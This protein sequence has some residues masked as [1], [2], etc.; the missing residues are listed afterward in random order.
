[1]KT[2]PSP[3]R[4]TFQQLL[5]NAFAVQESHISTQSLSAVMDVQRLIASGKL[6]LDG[7]MRHIVESA[8]KVANATGVAIAVLKR[9]QLAY[10]AGIGSS[11]AHVGRQ[12]TASLTVSACAK[13]NREIL[14][15]EN[16]QTDTRIEA[17]ICRQFGANALLI[18]P[19]YND[20][21]VAGVL[22]VRF[23]EA[24]IFDDREVRTYRL[25][26]E[27][28]ESALNHAAEVEPQLDRNENLAPEL[29][30]I[31][32]APQQIAPFEAEQI[33]PP[34]ED[35]VPPPEFMMLPQNEHSLFARCGAVLAD[36]MQLAVFKQ[37]AWLVT[38]LT[39]PAKNLIRPRR[40]RP[41]SVVVARK[42][43]TFKRPTLLRRTTLLTTTR[44]QRPK[45]LARPNHW[46][47]TTQAAA[48]E[49]SSAF[50]RTWFSATTLAHRAKNVT[51]PNRWR[52]SARAAA[53][54]FSSVFR[55]T[56]SSA[57]LLAQRAKNLN[58][59]NRWRNSALAAG[60]VVLAFITLIA[61]RSADPAKSLESSTPTSE[62]AID[63][64]AQIPKPLAGKATAAVKHAAVLP[65]AAAPAK[66]ALR[67]V[68]VGSG[69]VEYIGDDVTVRTFTN[70]S[71]AKRTRV[72]AGRTANIGDDVTVRYFTPSPSPTKTATR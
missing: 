29:P 47:S 45:I 65:K 20:G 8:Q 11:A 39:R 9:D 53:A 23:N 27:Q 15:V 7:V 6:D 13:T 19:I 24:H 68:R 36:I 59:S 3:D 4:E 69:E 34:E 61:Y 37:S 60:A 28:I 33:A 44:A 32:D 31:P 54:E 5:A 14:R 12:V 1:M 64:P 51:V 52:N 67:R 48:R 35:F 62:R 58:W 63:P 25:M 66:N 22:D 26:A 41:A 18:L 10:R 21:A 49:L 30:P 70:R 42:L 16:A 43:P 50:K 72:A 55:R 71:P 40:P 57:T 46:R 2:P 38:T 17:D 56:A